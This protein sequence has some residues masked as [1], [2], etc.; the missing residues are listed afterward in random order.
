ML[1]DFFLFFLIF[2]YN[3][4]DRNFGQRTMIS[5][6]QLFVPKKIIQ[7]FNLYIIKC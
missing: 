2:L 6:I 4:E 5:I 3:Y 1:A 7:L